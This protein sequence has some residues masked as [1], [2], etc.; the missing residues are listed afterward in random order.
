MPISVKMSKWPT[1]TIIC[2]YL[3]NSYYQDHLCLD[4]DTNY[5]DNWLFEILNEQA[6]ICV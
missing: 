6:I 3:Y 4:L 1:I 5:I 2:V